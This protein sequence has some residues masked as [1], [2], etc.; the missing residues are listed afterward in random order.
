MVTFT[1]FRIVDPETVFDTWLTTRPPVIVAF[2][3]PKIIED[4][5]VIVVR[6][7]IVTVVV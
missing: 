7:V 6:T 2:T 4:L 5:K 3:P 1:T